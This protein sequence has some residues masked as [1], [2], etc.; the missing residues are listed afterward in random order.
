[1]PDHGCGR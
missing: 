1:L